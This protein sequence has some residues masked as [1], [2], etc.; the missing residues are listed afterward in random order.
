MF[1]ANVPLSP[2]APGQSAWQGSA[3][4]TAESLH[5]A[6]GQVAAALQRVRGEE[7]D[8]V[9][10]CF[11]PRLKEPVAAVLRRSEQSERL[12]HLCRGRV[13]KRRR[14]VIVGEDDPRLAEPV[15]VGRAR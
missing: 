13:G 9:H 1:L 2:L 8:V 6:N 12:A 5:L 3:N 7:E 10:A 4:D 11:L 14:I 15:Q